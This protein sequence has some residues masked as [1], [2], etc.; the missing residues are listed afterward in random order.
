MLASFLLN[1]RQRTRLIPGSLF[2]GDRF[3]WWRSKQNSSA[4][5][6]SSARS[7]QPGAARPSGY[8]FH[9][10]ADV[11]TGYCETNGRSCDA[12]KCRP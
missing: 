11:V 5:G 7:R 1:C 4:V 6:I 3:L 12:T 10:A 2:H 9:P 8:G